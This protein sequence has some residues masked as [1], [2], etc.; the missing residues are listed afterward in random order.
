MLKRVL[1][2]PLFSFLIGS[3]L[4]LVLVLGGLAIVAALNVRQ[5][6]DH[7]VVEVF[8]VDDIVRVSVDCQVA[9][10]VKAEEGEGRV[11][12]GYLEDDDEISFSVYNVTGGAAWGIR[13][14]SDGNPILRRHRGNAD[15]FGIRAA[16]RAIVEAKSISAAGSF[17]GTEGCDAPLNV[18][19]ALRHRYRDLAT[20]E[21]SRSAGEP[22][23]EWEE[24]RSAFGAVLAA[25]DLSPIV[26]ALLGAVAALAT[27]SIRG[28]LWGRWQ[29]GGVV[30]VVALLFEVWDK[31]GWEGIGYLAEIVGVLALV[32]AIC[33]HFGNG[34]Y[35][36]VREKLARTEQGG[37]QSGSD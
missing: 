11:D 9:L 13:V 22:K 23:K 3:F 21:G 24:A 8:N 33:V 10:V 16:Q 37:G 7:V 4:L 5:N 1:K 20:V 25:A 34:L 36:L 35:E 31:F 32:L 26:V 18:A 12:L 15:A 14:L 30:A 17:H 28:R 27:P 6:Y 2:R 29:F 19:P